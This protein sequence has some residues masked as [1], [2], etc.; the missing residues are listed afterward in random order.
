MCRTSASE[1]FAI[2]SR[3]RLSFDTCLFVAR[4]SGGGDCAC[5]S[6][7]RAVDTIFLK[8]RSYE[9]TPRAS[10]TCGT[11]SCRLRMWPLFTTIRVV[12]RCWLRRRD[13]TCHLW[14]V[15]TRDGG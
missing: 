2:V 13:R 14:F 3:R 9:G 4:F 11:S 10:A 5:H 12:L 7:S 1:A 6:G 15:T 8:K